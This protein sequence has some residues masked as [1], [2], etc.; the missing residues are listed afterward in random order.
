MPAASASEL[1][2][3]LALNRVAGLAPDLFRQ[4]VAEFGTLE[5]LFRSP[6]PQ[7]LARL[8]VPNAVIV[9]LLDSGPLLESAQQDLK[10]LEEPDHHLV[11]CLDDGYPALLREI[12]AAPPLLYVSGNPGA[13][14]NL[15]VAVVGS[16]HP[17]R[18]GRDTARIFARDLAEAGIT[19]TSGLAAGVDGAAHGGALDGGGA[20]VAVLGTGIDRV[21]PRVHEALA[22]RI[23][24]SG[25]LVSEFPLGRPPLAVNFP[26]R[27][28]IISGL[29]LGVLVVEANSRSGSLITARFA[30]EQG[31][32]LFAIPGSIHSPQS[33]GCHLLIRQGAKLV[34]RVDE[35]TE[36]LGALAEFQIA[37]GRPPVNENAG[38]TLTDEQRSL[39]DELDFQPRT[40]DAL[41]DA[42][43]SPVER[44]AA[45][46]IELELRALIAQEQGGYV[47]RAYG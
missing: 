47:R 43:G 2:F 39:L 13:L 30:A 31:R 26:R 11:T 44:V 38:I 6:S 18:A 17:T 16:R 8:R 22:E 3:W 46:L 19:V 15:Q 37:A 12:P 27:N 24:A 4:F 21:Y 7:A 14:L 25:A 42:T 32:E 9:Q 10:W 29:S 23:A 5:A 34:E 35:I 20:T 1:A 40:V 28:R 33:R 36:E 41:V 45:V